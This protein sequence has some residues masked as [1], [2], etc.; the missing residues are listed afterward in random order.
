MRRLH[1][2][3]VLFLV[4]ATSLPA[5]SPLVLDFDPSKHEFM[6]EKAFRTT[7]GNYW[8]IERT[9]NDSKKIFV[10]L[11][12]KV[13]QISTSAT[14][15]AISFG[16]NGTAVL[17]DNSKNDKVIK[18]SSPTTGTTALTSVSITKKADILATDCSIGGDGTIACTLSGT[19]DN[20]VKIIP[21]DLAKTAKVKDLKD[22]KTRDIKD[23]DFGRADLTLCKFD[24]NAS[25]VRVTDAG[26]TIW[27]QNNVFGKKLF[28]LKAKD[29]KPYR[30]DTTVE[31]VR[32]L[33]DDTVIWY[34]HGFRGGEINVLKAGLLEEKTVETDPS[35]DPPEY[36]ELDSRRIL[37]F[38]G[39]FDDL[40]VT[41]NGTM[42]WWGDGKI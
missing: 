30:I 8:F 7:D 13:K 37:T 41:P 6:I 25:A 34:D 1:F 21:A 27:W 5:Y 40:H 3:P 12:D 23:E 36:R 14:Y 31:D 17:V 29:T 19:F 28:L 33:A 32:F 16:S 22:N 18:W 38:D 11:P 2:L 39:S 20:S 15:D 10:Q 42:L 35:D 24:A 4:T 26:T 9:L